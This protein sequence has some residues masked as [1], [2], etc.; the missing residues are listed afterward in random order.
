LSYNNSDS[1]KKDLISASQSDSPLKNSEG[2]DNYGMFRINFYKIIQE[3]E[4]F[5]QVFNLPDKLI[6]ETNKL[7]ESILDIRSQLQNDKEKITINENIQGVSKEIFEI[8]VKINS[9]ELLIESLSKSDTFEVNNRNSSSSSIT[10]IKDYVRNLSSEFF[11]L[12][13]KVENNSNRIENMNSD[14]LARI[15]FELLNESTRILDD[16]KISLKGSILRIQEQMR[17]KVD[18]INMDDFSKKFEQKLIN[19]V[20][21]KLDR[22]DLKKN[23]N[24]IN[25]KV[26]FN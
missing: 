21:K 16:F 10:N 4:K 17:E 1:T 26:L 8:K 22:N 15:K 24:L 20:S 6:E 18:K 25:K 23:T 2:K 5:F 12:K 19:E 14:L 11:D 9:M 3:E 7:Y 13:E